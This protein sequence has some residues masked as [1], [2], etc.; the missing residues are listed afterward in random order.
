MVAD[1]LGRSVTEEDWP[2]NTDEADRSISHP[3]AYLERPLTTLHSP[4]PPPPLHSVP[5]QNQRLY[6]PSAAAET[7]SSFTR[8]SRSWF[9]SQ[10]QSHQCCMIALTATFQ[11][12]SART[13]TA[14][15]KKQSRIN[16]SSSHT[17]ESP[18]A[19]EQLV[20]GNGIAVISKS[21]CCSGNTNSFTYHS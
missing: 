5:P 6:Q 18:I 4:H 11:G 12:S 17:D 13:Q 16:A 19:M 8:R 1:G 9:I 20:N 14:S 10:R 3:T 2:D 21:D 7:V 15:V